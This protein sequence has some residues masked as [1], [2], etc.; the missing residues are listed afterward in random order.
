M[1]SRVARRPRRHG[2]RVCFLLL[3]PWL[4][5]AGGCGRDPG[6]DEPASPADAPRLPHPGQSTAPAVSDTGWTAGI[7]RRDG[8]GGIATLSA[9][10]T[11]RHDGFDRI[12]LEFRGDI[13]PGY[14]LEYVDRPV[15]EC[16]SGRAVELEGNGWLE[17][18]LQPAK[19]HD[20]SGRATVASRD[21]RVDLPNLVR[22]RSTCDF[23][24]HVVWVAALQSP[25]PYRVLELRDPT[26]LVIDVGQGR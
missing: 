22:L 14:E 9:V 2:S 5:L 3:L 1:T 13:L 24:V 17:I 21:R 19:A 15:R 7:V 11:A 6:Y 26:R 8:R 16:G 20:D 10:R 12:V 4:L 23:E 25:E 18:R